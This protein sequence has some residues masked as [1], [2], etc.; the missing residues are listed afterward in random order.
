MCGG[1]R[2]A[3][4]LDEAG[5]STNGVI[6]SGAR[7]ISDQVVV[8]FS[9]AE[10]HRR[11]PTCTCSRS[12]TSTAT[13]RPAGINIYGQFAGGAAYLA[14][15]IADRQA[16][17]GDSRGDD[18]RRRQHRRQPAGERALLRGADHDRGQ[19]DARRLRI[20]RQ[21]RVRQGQRPSCCGSRTAAA[22]PTS[23]AR[24][25]RTRSR[26]AS[27]TNTYP[28]AD[29]QY[30]SANVIVNATG[31]TLFP[32]YGIKRFK[33]DSGRQIAVGFIG[34]VLEATP[35]IVTPTGV[36]GLTFAGRGRRGEPAVQQLERQGVD[37]LGARASTR[38]ASRPAGATLN[39]C[40][41]NLAGS[42]IADIA[43]RLDPSIKVIV[44]AHTHAEYRCTI[45]TDGVTR[46]ITSAVVVRPDPHATSRSP[47]D[48]KTGELVAAERD[49]LDRRQRAQHAGSGRRPR[50]PTRRRRTR[51]SQASSSQ[52]VDG[53]RAA[54]QPGDRQ[55][56]GRPDPDQHPVRRDPRSAT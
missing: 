11:R 5:G 30:L 40:A 13:S 26:T 8:S 41:G 34:E 9:E 42:A 44:S 22:A 38:A 55:D 52:Y 10:G 46:L 6:I 31:E 45:T 37:D 18:L 51:R 17:Y 54:R 16:Q 49:E 7:S 32:A 39:G 15:A 24:P 36:A 4:R 20:G 53:V 27:T 33:T 3:A 48:D 29:F 23:G 1:A 14:K 35:T 43:K 47:I 19:P 21:P 50:S 2:R 25:L 56:P 28:G 12:T